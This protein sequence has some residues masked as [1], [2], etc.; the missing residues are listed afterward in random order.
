M[1]HYFWSISMNQR[2]N[3]DL[4]YLKNNQLPYRHKFS[5]FLDQNG[6]RPV[7][8]VEHLEPWHVKKVLMQK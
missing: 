3:Q 2:E 8:E 6:V 1:Y 4:P 5:K 7:L